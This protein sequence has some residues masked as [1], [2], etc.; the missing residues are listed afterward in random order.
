M[1]LVPTAEVPDGISPSQLLSVGA[2]AGFLDL[3]ALAPYLL[4]QTEQLLDP[5]H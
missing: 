4:R 5:A 3:E 1:G 2:R